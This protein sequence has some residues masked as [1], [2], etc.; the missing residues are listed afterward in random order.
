MRIGT[1]DHE[2]E[3]FLLHVRVVPESGPETAELRDF[4]DRL[5][6]DPG[7]VA[8]YVAANAPSSRPGFAMATNMP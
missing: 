8:E 3:T 7:L 4:R 5:R 2:G 1:F 6:A